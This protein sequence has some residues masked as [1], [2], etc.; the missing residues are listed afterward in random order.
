MGGIC[1][2]AA[3]PGF[4][5]C[6]F[7]EKGPSLPASLSLSGKVPILPQNVDEYAHKGP[8]GRVKDILNRSVE[9][10]DF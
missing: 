7:I 1:P 3:H 9:I 2:L 4:S 10:T 8:A 5:V 6:I